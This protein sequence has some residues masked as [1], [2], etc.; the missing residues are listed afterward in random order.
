MFVS[1]ASFPF[2]KIFTY[3]ANIHKKMYTQFFFFDSSQVN[4]SSAGADGQCHAC[5]MTQST[6]TCIPMSAMTNAGASGHVP[7]GKPCC[8]AVLGE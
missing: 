3:S 6:G 1:K 5:N 2:Q 8:A 7:M 4:Q